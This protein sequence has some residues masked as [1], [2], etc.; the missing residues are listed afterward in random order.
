MGIKDEIKE[1]ANPRAIV[2]I[3]V[4]Q[5]S[6]T[7]TFALSTWALCY[8]YRP[9]YNLYKNKPRIM[10]LHRKAEAMI[11]SHIVKLSPDIKSKNLDWSRLASSFAEGW[12]FRRALLPI[13]YPASL[14]F[15]VYAGK[16]F[17]KFTKGPQ[18]FE[19]EEEEKEEGEEEKEKDLYEPSARHTQKRKNCSQHQSNW[20]TLTL[21][22]Q[23]PHFSEDHWM[24]PVM[25]IP[26]HLGNTKSGVHNVSL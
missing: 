25:M 19:S 16:Q 2:V 8:S 24:T 23:I 10:N 3:T 13:W 9:L 21:T 7:I 26:S 14:A 5:F 11:H 17:M 12:I 15:G 6:F 4:A 1:L 22:K 18:V 20:R